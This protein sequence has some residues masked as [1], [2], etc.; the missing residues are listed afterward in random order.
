MIVYRFGHEAFIENLDGEGAKRFGGRWNSKGFAM[1]YTSP[2]ISLALI[3]VL[4][5]AMAYTDLLNYRL[6]VL[7]VP[8]LSETAIKLEA[9]KHT[10][11]EDVKYSRFMGDSFISTQTNLSLSVPSAIIPQENNLLINPK[12]KDFSEVKLVD[13]QFFEFDVRLFK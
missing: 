12:H 1:L 5:H 2:T 7:E 4:A 3:E 13:I 11:R 9:M 10:W 8:Y 6:A